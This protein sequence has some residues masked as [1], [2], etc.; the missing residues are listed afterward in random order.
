MATIKEVIKAK[1]GSKKTIRKQVQDKLETALATL[2]PELGEKKFK[3]RIKKAGKL[4]IKGLKKQKD[5]KAAKINDALS[6]PIIVVKK[7]KKAVK[8]AKK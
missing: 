8:S 7:A 4:L 6:K 5:N 1:P 2:K 3:Q